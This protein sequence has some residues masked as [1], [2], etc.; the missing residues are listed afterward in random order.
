MDSLSLSIIVIIVLVL[1][2]GIFS[3]GEFG[4][5]SSRKSK[6]KDMIKEE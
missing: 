1:L 6:I 5:V 3:A 4:I 2:N